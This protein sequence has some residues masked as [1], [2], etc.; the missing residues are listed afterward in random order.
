MRKFISF[1]VSL[2]L[3]CMLITTN[4]MKSFAEVNMETSAFKINSFLNKTM[5]VDNKTFKKK[6]SYFSMDVNIPVVKGLK[7]ATFEKELNSEI[8]NKILSFASK[9]EKDGKEYEK[10]A[11]E[12]GFPVHPYELVVIYKV[13]YNKSNL[14]SYT[15][16]V[17]YYTGGAHGMTERY[18]YNI[19]NKASIVLKLQDLFKKDYNYKEV[20]NN[21]IMEEIKES[22]EGTYFANEF[23]TILDNQPFYFTD[24]GIVIYFGLYEIAPYVTG[25]PEFTVPAELFKENLIYKI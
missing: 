4:E 25:I 22:P 14:L 21:E 24:K 6:T 2:I 23:K 11:K 19:D 9:L 18:A 17:Y 1:M 15:M 7:N 10:I 3:F 5:K 8:E 12:K 13:Q 16:D 20:I